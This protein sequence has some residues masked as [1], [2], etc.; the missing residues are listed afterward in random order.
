M[1]NREKD[2]YA[3]GLIDGEGTITLTHIH[4]NTWRAPVVS[5]PS[6]S[7]ELISFF[8]RNYAGWVITKKVY[9]SQHSRS[10]E[11]RLTNNAALAF[12]NRI[13]PYLKHDEKRHRTHLLLTRYKIVTPRNGKYTPERKIAKLEFERRFF[14]PS[15]P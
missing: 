6:T 9:A 10:W 4:S 15:T 14:H 12:L 5:F 3:A 2:I 8:Y 13:S 7:Y 11:W 1:K